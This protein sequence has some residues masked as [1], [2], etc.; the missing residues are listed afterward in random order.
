MS[1]A[2]ANVNRDHYHHGNLRQALIDETLSVIEQTGGTEI[3]L[4]ML[5]Q[6]LGV[7]HAA[8]YAHFPDK[9]A[10]LKETAAEGF[11]RLA[12]VLGKETAC[13][14]ADRPLTHCVRAYLTFAIDQPG[15]YQL[16]FG[17]VTAQ[18]SDTGFKTARRAATAALE[19]LA[20]GT[21][22]PSTPSDRDVR[23]RRSAL[24]QGLLHGVAS[25][26]IARTD[27]E[28]T[29]SGTDLDAL[30][31]DLAATLAN[32]IQAVGPRAAGPT[33]TVVAAGCG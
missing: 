26:I 24:V 20:T 27:A 10:L 2:P 5:A 16:M 6:R 4:R 14:G 18:P 30:S 21:D 29:G 31:D 7:S 19:R 33:G 13:D 32:G 3:S 8:P 11:K 9:R 15:L 25:L 12:A 22:Q 28:G 1:S 17:G 23:Q